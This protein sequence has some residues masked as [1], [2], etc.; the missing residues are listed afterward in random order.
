[1]IRPVPPQIALMTAIQ[2][3]PTDQEAVFWP[4]PIAMTA[5]IALTTPKTSEACTEVVWS[6]ATFPRKLQP[7]QQATVISVYPSQP[8]CG[9]AV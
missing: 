1:M 3:A 9:R 4:S 8:M 7:A 6:S 5:T 2:S